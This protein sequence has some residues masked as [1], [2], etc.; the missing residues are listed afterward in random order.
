[1]QTEYI[2][3]RNSLISYFDSDFSHV[4]FVTYDNYLYKFLLNLPIN[5]YDLILYGNMG[6][7]GTEKMINYLKSL[8]N[9]HYFVLESVT[10][11]AQFNKEVINYVQQ[12]YKIKAIIGNFYVF[13]K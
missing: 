6:Y 7:H 4:C 5:K 9:D 13:H 11:G 3:N 2:D 8:E 12:N 10:N 1:M